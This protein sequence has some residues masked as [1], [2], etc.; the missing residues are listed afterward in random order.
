M[1]EVDKDVKTLTAV[2]RAGRRGSKGGD[3]EG[4]ERDNRGGLNVNGTAR[5]RNEKGSLRFVK[6][7][8]RVLTAP[9]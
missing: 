8:V 9:F 3:R 2:I 5:L 6:S 7:F 1:T 4:G